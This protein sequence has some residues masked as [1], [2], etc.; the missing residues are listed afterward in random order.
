MMYTASEWLKLECEIDMPKGD[1]NGEWFVEN[2]LPMI[3]ECSCCSMTMALPSA[4][5]DGNGNVYCA[6]CAGE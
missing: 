3:V 2:H 5:V 4:M 6:S 1:I